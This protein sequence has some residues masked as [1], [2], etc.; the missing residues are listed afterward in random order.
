MTN[1]GWQLVSNAA[2]LLDSR[3]REAVLGDLAE[4]QTTAWRGLTGILGLAIRRQTQQWRNWQPWLAS[5]GLALPC[6]FS[7]MGFSLAVCALFRQSISQPLLSLNALQLLASRATLLA[8]LA[9]TAG[10]LMGR[11]SPRTL[12]ASIAFTFAPC[13][14]CFSRFGPQL[15][16]PW[17]LMLFVLPAAF[18]VA[19]GVRRQRIGRVTAIVLIA[20]L[21]VLVPSGWNQSW[22]LLAAMIL[23]GSYIITTSKRK[24]Q[25]V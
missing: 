3:D 4:A 14:F 1:F 21:L 20:L 9:W 5:F 6:S 11:L 17:E 23:P 24:P 19:S 10:Y 18:G 15:Q 13:L 16:T 7:F 22:T 8:I 2:T 12:W 25:P